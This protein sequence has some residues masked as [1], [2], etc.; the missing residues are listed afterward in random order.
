MFVKTGIAMTLHLLAFLFFA[1]LL[2]GVVFGFLTPTPRNF[3]P[4]DNIKYN[5]CFFIFPE[6]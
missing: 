3:Q 2:L 6:N 5:H 1:S 4:G